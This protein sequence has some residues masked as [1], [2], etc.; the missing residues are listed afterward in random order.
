MSRIRRTSAALVVAGSMLVGT[1]ACTAPPGDT[2]SNAASIQ[3]ILALLAILHCELS[4]QFWV[5]ACTPL[6]IGPA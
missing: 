6:T 3:Q 1:A 5:Q 4:G 2:T